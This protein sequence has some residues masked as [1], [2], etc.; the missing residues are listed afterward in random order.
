MRRIFK[1]RLIVVHIVWKNLALSAY[2]NPYVLIVCFPTTHCSWTHTN[3][4]RIWSDNHIFNIC[5][6]FRL[7]INK[8]KNG[9]KPFELNW[10]RSKILGDSKHCHHFYHPQIFM[11]C[12]CSLCVRIYMYILRTVL[13]ISTSASMK[14]FDL[15]RRLG[16]RIQ[17]STCPKYSISHSRW[18]QKTKLMWV[19]YEI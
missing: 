2:S 10:F 13:M 8:Y 7:Q 1:S 11:A 18:P 19:Q 16:S 3:H 17:C 15:F 5:M 6:F 9:D 12:V 14:L 4:T